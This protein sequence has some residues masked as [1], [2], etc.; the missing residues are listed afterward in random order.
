[1]KL[2]KYNKMILRRGK[3]MALDYIEDG[4]E[5]L[6]LAPDSVK[7]ACRAIDREIKAGT[8]PGAVLAVVQRVLPFRSS[9]CTCRRIHCTIARH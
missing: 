3:D 5:L 2:L 4:A 8:A 1:M 9:A 7:A 6:G